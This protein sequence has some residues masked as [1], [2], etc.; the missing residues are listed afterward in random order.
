MWLKISWQS[1]EYFLKSLLN[2]TVLRKVSCKPKKKS[3]FCFELNSDLA[4]VE[5]AVIAV[6]CFY[7][8]SVYDRMS[9]L[10]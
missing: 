4:L 6:C 7:V 5:H 8:A 10:L 3:S 9:T 2:Y 1:E